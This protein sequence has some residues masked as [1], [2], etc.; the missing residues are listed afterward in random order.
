VVVVA[1]WGLAPW[2][3]FVILRESGR[4]LRVAWTA[5]SATALWALFAWI[6][7][8][9][10]LIT[11]PGILFDARPLLVLVVALAAAICFAPR[12]AGPGLSQRWLIGLQLLRAIGLVFVL[13]WTRG[14]LPGIFA[15]SAGWGD[16]VAAL[17]AFGVLI[18]YR[19]RPIPPR[20]AYFVAAVGIAD[21]VNAFFFGFFS[22]P[23]PVQLFAFDRPNQVI[24]YPT[25]LIPM[26]L[27]NLAL[28]F[29]VLSITE[30]RRT[31]RQLESGESQSRS[32][33]K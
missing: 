3:T 1:T 19:G 14:N 30:A 5:F 8:R 17:A 4:P 11:F 29:H 13:E 12:V 25:G 9:T 31:A 10:D 2:L 26:F 15:H 6:S 22:S 23:T 21:V 16:L 7:V 32:I 20:A 33:A 24:E 27:I 28:V 18:R